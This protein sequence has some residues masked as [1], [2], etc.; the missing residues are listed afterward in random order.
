VNES[1]A[2]SYASIV[3][4]KR[5]GSTWTWNVAEEVGKVL[6]TKS[7]YKQGILYEEIR[8]AS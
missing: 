6:R 4:G 5:C 1:I 8:D 7:R 2:S 3:V